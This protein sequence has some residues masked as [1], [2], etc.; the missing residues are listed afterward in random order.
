[1]V[2]NTQDKLRASNVKRWHTVPLAKE[3]SMAEHS[4]NVAVMSYDLGR[5]MMFNDQALRKILVKALHHDL[6]EI[7][8]GDSPSPVKPKRTKDWSGKWE[9][10]SVVE[11]CDILES[12]QFIDKYAIEEHGYTAAREYRKR[13]D[14][15]MEQAR[16]P[17]IVKFTNKVMYGEYQY[18]WG[19]KVLEGNPAPYKEDVP[20]RPDREPCDSDREARSEHVPY[21]LRDGVGY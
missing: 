2:L 20:L 5:V 13:I 11:Y 17:D 14:H 7:I 19:G 9:W 15:I 12:F 8:D 10:V 16:N 4:F 1:M 18:V 21:S 6:H 3:Q